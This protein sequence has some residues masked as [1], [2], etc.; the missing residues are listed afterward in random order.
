MVFGAVALWRQRRRRQPAGRPLSS[1]LSG[2]A[3]IQ[4]ADTHTHNDNNNNWLG[5]AGW[6]A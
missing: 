5:R 4:T 2:G 1:A 6:P 3:I